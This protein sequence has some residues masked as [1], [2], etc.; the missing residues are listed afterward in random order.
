LRQ[1]EITVAVMRNL[2]RFAFVVPESGQP[3]DP[4]GGMALAH[5]G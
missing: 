4:H 3:Y 2:L 5:I 1:L